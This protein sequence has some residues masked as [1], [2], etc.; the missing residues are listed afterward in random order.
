MFL[1]S[2]NKCNR[3]KFELC[4]MQKKNFTQIILALPEQHV[5]I[6]CKNN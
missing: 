2:M 4:K 1:C 6:F 3:N 5:K